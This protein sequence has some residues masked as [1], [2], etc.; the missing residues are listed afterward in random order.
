M[1][2]VREELIASI[3]AQLEVPLLLNNTEILMTEH[4]REL[5][6]LTLEEKQV[7]AENIDPLILMREGKILIEPEKLRIGGNTTQIEESK[8]HMGGEEISMGESMIHLQ[9]GEISM[10]E[11]MIHLQ[12]EEISMGESMIH[13]QEAEISME[14][15]MILMQ[16]GEI[17]MGENMI[18]LQEGGISMGEIHMEEKQ[19]EILM[20]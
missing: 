16:E 6:V 20:E 5:K 8:I 12:E 11:S 3:M 17:S 10:G 15:S 14:G 7:T 1:Q 9:E 18:L 19:L 4:E 2:E 13:L